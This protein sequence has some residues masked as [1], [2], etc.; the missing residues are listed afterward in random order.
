[1]GSGSVTMTRLSD[2]GRPAA[3]PVRDV[4]RHRV[5]DD[6]RGRR[7]IDRAGT[8]LGTV[9]D[10]LIN[11][12]DHRFRL[13]SVEHGGVIGFG[14]T[15]SLIPVETVDEVTASEIRIGRSSAQVADAPL[16]DP[17][18]MDIAD[19]CDDL[20]GYYGCRTSRTAVAA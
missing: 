14:A 15:P 3:R 6:V 19:F 5:M 2:A 13:I 7:V 8:V 20:Y 4:R 18:T 10:L 1:M 11:T 12:E 17:S 9:E 16:Y